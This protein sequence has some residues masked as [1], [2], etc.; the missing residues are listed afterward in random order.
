MKNIM[1]VPETIKNG[2]TTSFI[3]PS[4]GYL[5][6]IIDI[7]VNISLSS[8]NN[9]NMPGFDNFIFDMIVLFWEA[10]NPLVL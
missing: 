7:S 8:K 10:G 4:L 6:K 3:T 1:G 5:P 9:Q 2:T